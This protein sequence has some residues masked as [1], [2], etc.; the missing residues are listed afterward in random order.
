MAKN[1]FFLY[2]GLLISGLAAC[3]VAAPELKKDEHIIF[4]GDSITRAGER[5]AGYVSIVSDLLQTQFPELNI[6]CTG[7]GV[8][9]NKVTDCQ[10]RLEKDVL[11]KKPTKVLIAIGINDVWHWTKPDPVTKAKRKGT[12]AKNY[13]AGLRDL[14]TRIHAAH[15]KVLLCTPTV[16]GEDLN[17]QA[18][19]YQMLDEFSEIA[20][21]VAIQTGASLIDTRKACVDYL[22]VENRH[23][24]ASGIL[25]KDGVHFN[26]EGN[27]FFARQILKALQV[28]NNLKEI[29]Y[30]DYHGPKADLDVYLLIGQSNMA[31]RAHLQKEDMGEIPG[32]YLF[33]AYDQWGVARNPLNRYS[34]IRKEFGMQ[35]LNLGYTFAKSMRQADPSRHIGLVVNARGGTSIKQWAKGTEFYKEA[36]RRAQAAQKTGVLKGILWHQGEQDAQDAQYLDKLRTLITDLRND[37]GEPTLPF[38]AGQ[39]NNVELINKQIKKLPAAVPY[40]GFASSEGLHAMDRW[41][42]DTESM[43][44]LGKRYAEEMLKIHARQAVSGVMEGRPGSTSYV[45]HN[46]LYK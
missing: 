30:S 13:E 22:S 32:V 1:P 43:K 28:D 10:K 17:K 24:L 45:R 46:V 36:L 29:S 2:I 42:F 5:P 25:T 33:N 4:L 19:S 40:T 27:L 3:A 31:G 18:P 7:A 20:R 12:T 34:S 38:V 6:R 15:A 39:I 26:N 8:S 9:G 14:I 11:S 41:H 21:R 44:L 37:L 16:I 23:R 35:Q